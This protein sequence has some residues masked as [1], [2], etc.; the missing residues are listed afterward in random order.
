MP[1]ESGGICGR[2][3]PDLP[4]GYLQG[5][6]GPGDG[7]RGSVGWFRRPKARWTEQP[8]GTG[9]ETGP[10]RGNRAPR[11]ELSSTVFGVRGVTAAEWKGAP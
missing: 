11:V 7:S 5:G 6:D 1:P 10:P 8:V 9:F 4:L 3:T 2:L